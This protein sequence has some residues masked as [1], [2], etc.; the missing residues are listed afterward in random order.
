MTTSLEHM[1]WIVAVADFGGFSR[2]AGHFGL[3]QPALSSVVQAAEAAF[4]ARLFDRTT[5]YIGPTAFG[6]L[7]V[8][9]MRMVIAEYEAM[10]KDVAAFRE[11]QSGFLEI[12]CLSSLAVAVI[13]TAVRRLKESY[14]AI[15]LI[16]NEANSGGVVQQVRE[17]RVE[18]GLCSDLQIKD[19]L[20]FTPLA[21]E[22]LGVMY[23]PR[24]FPHIKKLTWQSA[25][26]LPRIALNEH[27]GIPSLLDKSLPEFLDT[28]PPVVEVTN[29]NTI[30]T[31]A[32]EGVGIGILPSFALQV[33]QESELVVQMLD[34]PVIERRIGVVSRRG[35]T[36]SPSAEV[37]MTIVSDLLKDL[38]SMRTAVQ[39]SATVGVRPSGSTV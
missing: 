37:F 29:L 21:G 18:L 5:R 26:T 36:L 32:R 6:E 16:I 22:Q 19:D 7:I 2:A 13:P 15:R 31:L 4:G 24:H 12:A 10:L 27:T 33:N 9:R 39:K 30:R 34:D 20:L 14:P 38:S 23:S 3:S 8:A 1:R 17:R 28:M 11:S 35:R 25:L